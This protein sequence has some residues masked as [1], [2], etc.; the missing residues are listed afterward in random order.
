MPLT[1][2]PLGYPTLFPRF[3]IVSIKTNV[4]ASFYSAA[5]YITVFHRTKPDNMFSD[6]SHPTS[7]SA[8]QYRP[9]LKLEDEVQDLAMREAEGERMDIGTHQHQLHVI[10]KIGVHTTDGMRGGGAGAAPMSSDDPKLS[11]YNAKEVAIHLLGKEAI[12][13][14]QRPFKVAS[15]FGAVSSPQT[16]AAAIAKAEKCISKKDN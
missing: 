10:W 11:L 5:C 8:A 16:N 4:S 12:G 14:L 7:T 2:Q 9:V 6:L 1:Q 13:D 3:S 15:M